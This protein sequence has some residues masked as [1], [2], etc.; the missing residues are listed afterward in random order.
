MTTVNPDQPK[1]PWYNYPIVWLV[2]AI[3]ASAVIVGIVLITLSITTFDGLVEDDYYKKGKEI[4]L[5]LARDDFAFDNEISA[6][7]AI[8]NETG[9]VGITLVSNKAYVFPDTLGLA[10]L[11]PTQ[12]NQDRKLLLERGPDGRF[13]ANLKRP[14]KDGRWYVRVSEKNWRLQKKFVS[15]REHPVQIRP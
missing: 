5:D 4:N 9:I 3:P 6:K 10:F 14:L 15:P 8:D 12:S 2:I 13:F 7:I 1:D 11:H